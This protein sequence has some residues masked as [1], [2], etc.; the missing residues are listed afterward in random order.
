MPT[1]EEIVQKRESA[2]E[3][4]DVLHEISHLLNTGLTRTQLSLS[5][6]LIENGV[7]PEAL[8]TII[9]QVRAEGGKELRESSGSE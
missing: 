6:S 4:I 9:K 2:K 5:V 1:K 7:N 8:A 3:I